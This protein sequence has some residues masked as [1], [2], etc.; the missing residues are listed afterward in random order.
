MDK[1]LDLKP[2]GPH[3]LTHGV[4]GWEAAAWRPAL[5]QGACGGLPS[6]DEKR[7]MESLCP[8][9]GILSEQEKQR[10]EGAPAAF[11]VCKPQA[12]VSGIR[13]VELP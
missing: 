6:A 13:G 10:E 8:G 9:M 7:T 4:T 2:R 1:G 5:L 11:E 12:L 3:G